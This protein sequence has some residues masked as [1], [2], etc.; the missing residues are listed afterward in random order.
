MWTFG[1]RIFASLVGHFVENF[2]ARRLAGVGARASEPAKHGD[3]SAQKLAPVV[4]LQVGRTQLL[5]IKIQVR[6]RLDG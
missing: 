3:G 1:R 4:S 5:L 6:G 2:F